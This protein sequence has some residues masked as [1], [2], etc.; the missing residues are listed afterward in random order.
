[1][2][3]DELKQYDKAFITPKIAAEFLGCDPHSIRLAA[4]HRPQQLKFPTQRI[5]SRTKI[6]TKAFIRFLEGDLDDE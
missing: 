2:T 6:P 3:L 4:K 1:M 5:G